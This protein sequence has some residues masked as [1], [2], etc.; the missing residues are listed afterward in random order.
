M[1]AG[2]AVSGLGLVQQQYSTQLAA[3]GAGSARHLAHRDQPT[4]AP[5]WGFG[6]RVYVNHL[7]RHRQ[8]QGLLSGGDG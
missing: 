3:D 1:V 6:I 2:L 5:T 4:Q 7:Q 8:T